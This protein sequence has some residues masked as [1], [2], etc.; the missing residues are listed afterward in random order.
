MVWIT[1]RNESM[2]ELGTKNSSLSKLWTARHLLKD[3]GM[4][5]LNE[6]R[7]RHEVFIHTQ[8]QKAL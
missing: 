3:Q 4:L 5:L 7:L 1:S 6:S 2:S 8:T